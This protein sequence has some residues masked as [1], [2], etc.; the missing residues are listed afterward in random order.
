M[1][2]TLS[3]G[4]VEYLIYELDDKLDELDDLTPTSPTYDVYAPDGTLVLSAQPLVVPQP[5]MKVRALI[6]T[7]NVLY[8]PSTS[9]YKVYCRFLT[10]PEVPYLHA[11][12]FIVQPVP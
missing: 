10:S 1:A 6:D 3:K 2:E 12:D 4:T 8:A 7:T 11:G 9:P 5:G